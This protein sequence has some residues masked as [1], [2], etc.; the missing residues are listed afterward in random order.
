VASE[1]ESLIV[2]LPE[3]DR[4]EVIVIDLGYAFLQAQRSPRQ[5]APA[6]IHARD[7]IE[8]VL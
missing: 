5:R 7:A 4:F 2:T 6:R 3:I 1:G 8:I